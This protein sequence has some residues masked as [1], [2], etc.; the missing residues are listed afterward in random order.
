M[1][2]DLASYPVPPVSTLGKFRCQQTRTNPIMCIQSRREVSCGTTYK[3]T[4]TD[5]TKNIF[6]STENGASAVPWKSFREIINF[7][8][9]DKLL[10][11]P[12]SF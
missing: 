8:K 9:G 4:N 12:F 5:A 10:S 6:R 1:A 7:F 2:P 11:S 3:C